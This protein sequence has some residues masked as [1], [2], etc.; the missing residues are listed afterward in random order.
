MKKT[1]TEKKTSSLAYMLR[2]TPSLDKS[3]PL[4]SIVK[5]RIFDAVQFPP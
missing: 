5:E 1:L 2:K 3:S 4:N